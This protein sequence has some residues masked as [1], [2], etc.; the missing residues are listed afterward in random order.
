MSENKR[1]QA[2]IVLQHDRRLADPCLLPDVRKLEVEADTAKDWHEEIAKPVYDPNEM[3]TIVGLDGISSISFLRRDI[4]SV[5]FEE[6]KPDTSKDLP[7]PTTPTQRRIDL[8][9]LNPAIL[10][11]AKDLLRILGPYIPALQRASEQVYEGFFRHFNNAEFEEVDKLMYEHMTESERKELFDV[12]TQDARAAALAKFE[13]K[14]LA[15]ELAWKIL[16]NLL[17]KGLL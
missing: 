11:D 7:S 10:E 2:V 12:V 14:E 13:R 17:L 9:L 3:F 6:I 15:K 4:D 16:I 8:A 5:T 1:Y